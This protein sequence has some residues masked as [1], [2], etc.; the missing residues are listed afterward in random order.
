MNSLWGVSA[1]SPIDNLKYNVE[2][3]NILKVDL[4]KDFKPVQTTKYAEPITNGNIVDNIH[5]KWPQYVDKLKN[6]VSETNAGIVKE[7]YARK[8][9]PT[10]FNYY[11]PSLNNSMV[12][13]NINLTV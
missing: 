1:Y 7:I 4:T 5:S 6:Y 2:S 8:N 12:G 10:Q 11:N 13:R 3:R 9:P